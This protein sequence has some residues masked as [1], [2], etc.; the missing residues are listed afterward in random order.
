MIL[1]DIFLLLIKMTTLVISMCFSKI[2]YDD[3][4]GMNS[5]FEYN[6][7]KDKGRTCFI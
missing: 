4:I 7:H 6:I 1:A 5:V 3:H 2:K